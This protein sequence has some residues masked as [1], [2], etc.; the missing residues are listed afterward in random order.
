[1]YL[2]CE[3]WPQNNRKRPIIKKGS[4]ML[5]IMTMLFFCFIGMS[6][7]SSEAQPGHEGKSKGWVATDTYKVMNFGVLA[8]GLFLLLRKPVSQALNSR[9]S[10]IKEQ[11]DELE[12]KKQ[13][14][15]KQLKEYAEKFSSLEQETEKLIEDYIRQGNEAKARIIDEAKKAAE[16]LEEQA[17][18]NIDHEFKQAKLELQREIMEKALQKSEEI[19]K[20]KITA[21]DQEKLVD[22][23]LKKVVA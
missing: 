14:A 11:L 19:L 17:R 10:G 16:K 20:D 18:R 3:K 2:N 7:A 12:E 21:K 13:A 5:V 8:I 1:M 4:I 9:I 23:Y 6:L 15:E 22:E